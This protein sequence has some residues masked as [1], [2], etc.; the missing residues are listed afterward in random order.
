MAKFEILKT[1]KVSKSTAEF[2]VVF[3]Q[4]ILKPGDVFTTYDTHH[5]VK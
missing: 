5:P 1:R 3:I 2:N 4:G